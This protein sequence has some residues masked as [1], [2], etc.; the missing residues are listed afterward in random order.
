MSASN[1]ALLVFIAIVAF[2]VGAA[3]NS[4][5]VSDDIDS[6]TLLS[7]QLNEVASDSTP[8]EPQYS[9]NTINNLLGE[10]LTLVNFWASWCAPCREEMP[11]FEAFYQQAK[12]QGFEVIGVAIDSPDKAKPMLDSMGITYPILYA[13]RTGMEVMESAGNPQGLLPYSLILDKNGTVIEQVLGTV[14]EPQILEWLSSVNINVTL[15]SPDEN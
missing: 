12:S 15:A 4:A 5:R 6:D 7:A 2:A 14:H 13:E 1:K 8:D 9:A 11:L 3:I 10:K